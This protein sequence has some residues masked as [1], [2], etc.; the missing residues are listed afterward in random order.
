MVVLSTLFVWIHFL[1]ATK[2]LYNW[3]CPLVGRLVGRSVG[4]TFVR[5]STPSHL[6]AYLAL[7]FIYKR[8]HILNSAW[9]L[10]NLLLFWGSI[11]LKLNFFLICKKSKKCIN[12]YSDILC[13]F[14]KKSLVH[15]YRALN[16]LLKLIDKTLK[17]VIF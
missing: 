2:H 15:Y 14:S 4:N 1:G 12:M 3:L 6:L 13:I 17:E 11:S 16:I 8:Q 9:V 10:L 7:F 5:R